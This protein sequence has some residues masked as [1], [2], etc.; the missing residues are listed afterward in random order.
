[1]SVATEISRLQQAKADIKTAI[2]AKG[3]T[4]PSSALI[5]TYDDY[6]AQIEGGGGGDYDVAVSYTGHNIGN[7]A[8]SG[9]SVT[10]VVIGDNVTSVN[11]GAF[12]ACT[13]LTDIHIG[14]GCTALVGSCFRD[15]RNVTSI[16]FSENSS[17]TTIGGSG[18]TANTSTS[19]RVFS[20]VNTQSPA[21]LEIDFPEGLELIGHSTFVTAT[22]I[23]RLSFP[24]TVVW[25]GNECFRGLTGCESITFNSTTPPTLGGSGR[26]FEDT[27][28]DIFVP[29]ASLEAYK[30]AANWENYSSQIKAIPSSG[31]TSIPYGA[32]MSQYYN[33]SF[34][35]FVINDSSFPSGYNFIQMSLVTGGNG[36]MTD[37][38]I[39]F[40][41][42]NTHVTS[43]PCDVTGND[44]MMYWFT[45]DSSW[46]Q[47]SLNPF[48]DLK[49]QFD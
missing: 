24:S 34:S 39:D 13:S 38:N 18:S 42:G 37:G 30:T 29:A 4:V 10:S 45:Y 32:D 8:F 31:L 23:K 3:V 12:S 41:V 47:T 33:Q 27:T 48:Q 44:T 25:I 35:R 36:T 5:D 21:V 17:L 6:V 14:S 22:G 28:C 40:T 9:K 43:L 20:N 49:I 26:W 11:Y 2:E 19:V 1:M 16:T 46:Q 7:G 15:T